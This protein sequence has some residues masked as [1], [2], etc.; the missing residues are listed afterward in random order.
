MGRRYISKSLY[1]DF[2]HEYPD[3]SPRAKYSISR[4]RFYKWLNAYGIF[5]EGFLPEENRDSIGRWI[6][7][8]E[9]QKQKELKF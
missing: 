7:F 6:R 8:K 3:Y 9:I 5:K 4:T 2:V 1:E